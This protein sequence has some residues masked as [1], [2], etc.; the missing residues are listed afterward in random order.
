M[1]LMFL[2]FKQLKFYSVKLLLI[3]YY[4]LL[5]HFLQIKRQCITV[6]RCRTYSGVI[7]ETGGKQ[8]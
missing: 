3:L 6:S 4:Q 2:H 1:I 5:Y 8:L 7:Y